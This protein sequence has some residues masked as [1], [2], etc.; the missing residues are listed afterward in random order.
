[1]NNFL[2]SSEKIRARHLKVFYDKIVYEKK[3]LCLEK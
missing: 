1:M 2:N 3:F